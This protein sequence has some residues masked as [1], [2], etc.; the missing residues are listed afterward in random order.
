MS[1]LFFL[2]AVESNPSPASRITFTQLE[3]IAPP[4][5]TSSASVHTAPNGESPNQLLQSVLLTYNLQR[6]KSAA[7]TQI[8]EF[9]P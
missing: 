5:H 3:S 8:G 4:E 2:F 6:I 1:L 7:V 9:N